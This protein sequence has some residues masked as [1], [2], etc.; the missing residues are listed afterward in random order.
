MK[1]IIFS[2]GGQPYESKQNSLTN[3]TQCVPLVGYTLTISDL[4]DILSSLMYIHT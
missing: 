1:L 4:V 3:I 2:G